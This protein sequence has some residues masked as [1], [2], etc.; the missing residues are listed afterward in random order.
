MF[1]RIKNI[2]L[3]SILISFAS[4]KDS[5]QKI[6]KSTDLD[7]KYEMAKKYYNKKDYFKALPLFEELLNIY[8]GTKSVEKIYYYYAYCYY[9][10]G[11][12][13]M[14]AYH[15]KNLANTYP[16]GEY[17]EESHYMYAYT[18]YVLS[19]V[20]SLDQTYTHK[21]MEA[22]QLFINLYPQSEK[23]EKCNRYIDKMRETLK[24]KGFNSAKL[25]FDLGYYQ[26]ASVSFEN[27]LKEYPDINEKEQ[28][29]YLKMKS[30]YLFAINSIM[31]K[32][33][34]RIEKALESNA[35]F[36]ERYPESKHIREANNLL[37]TSNKILTK[38]NENGRS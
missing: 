32:Q 33:M 3:I 4:C 20:P 6:L 25:Y 11:E 31:N 18:Q 35:D 37:E 19:P 30:D 28:A 36:R 23:V 10:Q 5:Y 22:L 7:Y 1:C 34:A 21:A 29:Y 8:K 24:I 17:T 2:I 14:A 13:L 27:L 38:L 16:N 15:F 12:Y 26:A 9:G